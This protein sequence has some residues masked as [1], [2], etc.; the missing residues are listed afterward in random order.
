MVWETLT[1]LSQS[2]T[3]TETTQLLI[4]ALAK[5]IFPIA[6]MLQGCSIKDFS[7]SFAFVASCLTIV[8][9]HNHFELASNQSIFESQVKDSWD[10]ANERLKSDV[11]HIPHSL[12]VA[13][14]DKNLVISQFI[15]GKQGHDADATSQMPEGTHGEL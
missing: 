8:Q 5:L 10:V 13:N 7:I 3:L 4:M 14:N 2:T 9:Q 12:D 11:D 1:A 6:G 15:C